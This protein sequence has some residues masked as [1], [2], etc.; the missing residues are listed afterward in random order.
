MNTI[1]FQGLDVQ[2]MSKGV[3]IVALNSTTDQ[4]NEL[5]YIRL[6]Q[7]NARLIRKHLRLPVGIITDVGADGF[8]EFVFMS[9]APATDRHITLNNKHESYAWHND[10]RRQLFHFSPFEKTLLLDADYLIQSDRF[11]QCFDFD[12]PFQI[13]KDVHDPTGRNS[14]DKY[15][16]LPNRTIPQKWATAIYWNR[17]AK[18]HFE[19][20][21]MI[22]ENYQYYARIFGFNPTQ[23]RNDMVFS[24][25]SHMLP[26]Y[27]I[28]FKM[29]MASADCTIDSANN[30]GIK[31]KY[32][33]NVQRINN[34]IHLLNK[35]IMRT[36]NLDILDKWSLAD[37]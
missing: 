7:I 19:Y 25:V 37:D 32:G 31:I 29:W 3:L 20:A 28:P 14:F 27:D 13:I 23:Y 18:E 10:Y 22:A 36:S 16:S 12:A 2:K 5:D 6:A 15:K 33:N 30:K 9:K 26:S 21:N 35:D 4:K 1:I 17:E 11:L 24:V 34:D 8:D